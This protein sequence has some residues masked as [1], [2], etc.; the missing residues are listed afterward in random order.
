MEELRWCKSFLGLRYPF[1]AFVTKLGSIGTARLDSR[2]FGFAA[3]GYV[4]DVYIVKSNSGIWHCKAKCWRSN[5]RNE[6]P[7]PIG[8]KF[9]SATTLQSARC[10]CAAG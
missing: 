10:D 3:E 6:R 1:S 7:W 5:H 9:D 2:S 4:H 8:I